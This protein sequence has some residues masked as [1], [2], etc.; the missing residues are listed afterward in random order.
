MQ[1]FIS[2]LVGLLFGTGLI[3]A[4]M[5]DPSKVTGF[6][7]LAGR[8]DPSLAFVM[9]GAILVGVVGFRIAGKRERSLLGE[10]M[11]LPTS[12]RIDRRLV[13]GSLAFG[14]GWGLAGYCPGPALASLLSGST[15]PVLFTLAMVC[16]MGLFELFERG[17]AIRARKAA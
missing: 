3:V 17:A 13:L 6:L 2:L 8:W 10:A 1:V 14:A 15:K 9:G 16:G 7:D 4:G 11:R 12:T 5:T